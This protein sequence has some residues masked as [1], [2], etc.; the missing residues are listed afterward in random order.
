MNLF[1]IQSGLSEGVIR[2][3]MSYLINQLNKGKTDN[4]LLLD[5]SYKK[6]LT[7]LSSSTLFYDDYIEYIDKLDDVRNIYVRSY[8]VFVKLYL[9]RLYRNLNFRIIFDFRGLGS[10]E[11]FARRNS[12]LKQWVLLRLEHFVYKRADVVHCVSNVL[13]EFLVENFGEREVKIFPCCVTDRVHKKKALTSNGLQFVYVGGF[14]FWQKTIETLKLYYHIEKSTK[15]SKLTIITHDK[16]SFIQ[17]AKDVGLKNVEIKSLHQSEVLIDLVNYDFGFLLRDDILMN[18][19]ASPI[20]FSEYI[21][22]GVFPILTKGIGDYSD[23][24]ASKRIGVIYNELDFD[25]SYLYQIINEENSLDRLYD[26][27]QNVIWEKYIE[28]YQLSLGCE[29]SD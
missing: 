2:S 6:S 15:N 26:Y 4:F 27:S 22:R 20:K 18:N 29:R 3:Q 1:L 5:R 11:T 16:K 8:T 25:V 17:A 7:D 10:A 24:V 21:S 12:Y 19:V 28:E 23:I 13:K 14:S 9:Y